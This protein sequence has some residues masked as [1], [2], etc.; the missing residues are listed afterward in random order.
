MRALVF[1]FAAWFAACSSTR[2]VVVKE[3]SPKPWV[4]LQ[5]CEPDEETGKTTC[6]TADFAD[7]LLGC[8]EFGRENEHLRVRLDTLTGHAAVD[9]AAADEQLQ[10]CEEKLASPWRSW[11]LWLIVG[12]AGGAAIGAGASIGAR[13]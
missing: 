2:P 6:E 4:P 11:W 5:R 13:Y 1:L 3:A 7:G 9:L 12:L 8:V 10:M